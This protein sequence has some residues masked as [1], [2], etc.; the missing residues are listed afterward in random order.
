VKRRHPHGIAGVLDLVSDNET[1]KRDITVLTA[2]GRIASAVHAV[3][4]TWFAE[5]GVAASNIAMYRTP[6]SSRAG[7]EELAAL[8]ETG[9][10][11]VHVSAKRP[12]D[13]AGAMLSALKDRSLSGKIVLAVSSTP[14]EHS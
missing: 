11:R 5:R 2:T 7:L 10:V 9:A 4:D 3:D 8:I 1:I 12:L 14:P 13:D 6:Q